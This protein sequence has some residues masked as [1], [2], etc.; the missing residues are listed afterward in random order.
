[1]RS[2]LLVLSVEGVAKHDASGLGNIHLHLTG[3]KRKIQNKSR[4]VLFRYL[5][6]LDTLVL[7]KILENHAK[8]CMNQLCMNQPMASQTALRAVPYIR[9]LC[10]VSCVGVICFTPTLLPFHCL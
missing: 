6:P 2:L 10:H 3:P 8:L 9:L 4:T 1:M 5:F 7:S